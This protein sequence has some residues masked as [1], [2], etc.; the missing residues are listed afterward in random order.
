MFAAVLFLIGVYSSAAFNILTTPVYNFTNED[1]LFGQTIIKAKNGIF[2]PSPTYGKVL[3]CTLYSTCEV[4]TVVEN[5]KKQNLRPIAS[6]S[7]SVNKED[8]QLLFCNQIRIKEKHTVE[9]FNGRCG[10]VPKQ[11]WKDKF[12]PAEE[13]SDQQKSKSSKANGRR[14]RQAEQNDDVSDGDDDEEDP[15]TEI[16]FVLDGSGSIEP[17]DFE[18]AKDFISNVMRKVWESC[19]TCKFGIVQFGSK[20]RTELSLLENDNGAEALNKV[21]GI[22]QV[23]NKTKTASALY[24]VLTE[25][26]V[27]ENGSK[28]D[29]RKMIIVLSDGEMLGEKRNLSEVLSMPQMNGILRYAIGVGSD[30]LKSKRAINEMTQIAGSQERFFNVSNYAALESILS[31]IEKN[32]FENV[33][34]I[35]KGVGFQFELAEAGFSSH[36]THDGSMLFGSVGSYDW[37]GGVIL[38]N[39]EKETLTFFNT[40][41]TE[42]GASYLGYTVTSARMSTQTLYISGAPRYNLTGA[43]FIFNGTNQDLIKGDQV[44]SYFGSVLCVLDIDNNEETDYLLVGAPH[45][46]KKGEEGK[47]LVYKLHPGKFEKE[48]YELFGMGKHI[49]ARFGSAI[50]D[51]GD[52]D[53]N[54]YN[55][56]AV[57]S[58]LEAADGLSDAS[59]SIYIFNGFKGGIKPQYSQRISPSDFGMKLVHFGQAI[60]AISYAREDKKELLIS[61]GSEGVITVFKTVPV[62]ILKPE[63]SVN[64]KEIS[65]AQQSNEKSSEF[66]TKL[67]I[68]F[69]EERG[70]IISDESLSIE[71][72]IDLDSN[73][74]E[75]RLFFVN[76]KIP[77]LD[78]T[79]DKTC[80][81]QGLKYVGCYDCFTPIR[82]K[83]RFTLASNPEGPPVRILDIFS[84]AEF[85][86]EITF[87]KECKSSEMCK[88]DISLAKSKLSN[89]MVII[90]SSPNL[91]ITFDLQN[92]GHSSYMTTL[93]VTYPP[94]L[95]L[96]K[97][98]KGD[99]EVKNEN[100]PIQCKL[101]HPIFKRAA[102]TTVTIVWTPKNTKAN[103]STAA[104]H[105]LLTSGNNVSEELDSR[106][107]VFG[108]KHALQIQLRGAASPNRFTTEEGKTTTG[109]KPLNFT[110]QLLG[111]N[112][113]KDQITVNITISK[114]AP[115]TKLRI[116]SVE[117]KNCSSNYTD[118]H[119]ECTL[120][121]LKEIVIMTE[122]FINDITGN[123][124]NIEATAT[125][126]FDETIYDATGIKKIE[127]VRVTLNQ[128][129]VVQ[130]NALI[131]GGSIGGFILLIIIIIILIKC[132]FFRRRRHLERVASIQS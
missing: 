130:S 2:A 64:N 76:A 120:T 31:L 43:V 18:L 8:E 100:H 38:K 86:H 90:G 102:Q 3:K 35:K 17:K 85:K 9:M 30:V 111:E 131:T 117:P 11:I 65:L 32:I 25:I 29:S 109:S 119:I 54:K 13:V 75:K 123:N 5:V 106:T 99:C 7:S 52:I 56:V 1:K 127:K 50:V 60:S 107:Y 126:I 114:H 27:P 71:F 129:K 16:A 10:C 116:H 61:V 93:N 58:P 21:K 97:I 128:L 41:N 103:Q 46:H 82:I 121:D 73:K 22:S 62:I 14:R 79:T 40:T 98:E 34:G 42:P 95:Q 92:T 72:Q 53:G 67:I 55:D 36:L 69:Y 63:I 87:E 49:Y 39:K 125:L 110:F 115:N 94:M 124:E 89:N 83:G 37:S 88:A 113:Y 101:L 51:I 68:C 24:H 80:L 20:I 48:D 74:E 26:F 6:V 45:F 84:P 23:Y 4:I 96:K 19:F 59:G 91:S 104:I 77:R 47:V 108:L 118:N 33:E 57:G 28:K 81:T 112:K 105:A 132:G 44:G 15:G 12:N 66:T 122:V 78:M 70:K